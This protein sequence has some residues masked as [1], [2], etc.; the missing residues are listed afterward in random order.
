MSSF[1]DI[2]EPIIDELN[3]IVH[4]YDDMQIETHL[5][6]SFRN[7]VTLYVDNLADSYDNNIMELENQIKKELSKILDNQNYKHSY[8]NYGEKG[9]I[10]ILVLKIGE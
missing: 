5:D 3:S 10:I 6:Y 2:L 9:K 4:T 8:L 7:E 1:E